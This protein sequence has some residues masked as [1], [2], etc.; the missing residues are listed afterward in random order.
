MSGR[1]NYSISTVLLN[2]CSV[3]VRIAYCCFARVLFCTVVVVVS[4]M[5][6]AGEFHED[7]FAQSRFIHR[8][9][10]WFSKPHSFLRWR[11]DSC[12][13]V[14]SHCSHGLAGRD[15]RQVS[16][17]T[18][19]DKLALNVRAICSAVLPWSAGAISDASASSRTRIRFETAFPTA[20][21][22]SV[23]TLSRRS[24]EANCVLST[25]R[26]TAQHRKD[27]AKCG[28]ASIPA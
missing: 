23:S 8:L 10:N 18:T 22:L 6:L 13:A 28:L 12:C 25:I 1:E 16:A 9:R 14:P 17:S 26:R 15:V 24:G 3:N 20:W 11:G 21:S 7:T 2:A 5:L 19:C 4:P 27:D